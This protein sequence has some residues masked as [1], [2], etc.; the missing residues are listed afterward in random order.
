[1]FKTLVDWFT[2]SRNKL[3]P[4]EIFVRYC[5]FSDVSAH[6]TRFQEFSRERCFN[7]LLSTLENEQGVNVTFFLDTFHPMEREHFIRK[8]TQHPLVEF[9]AGSEAAS[10]L[11]MLEH[12]YNQDFSPDTIIYFLE[13]DY[14]HL[15]KWPQV[16]REAFTLPN[17]D[18]V[19]LYDHKDKYLFPQYADLKSKIFHTPSCHWRTTPSTTNTYSMLFKTLKKHID[20]HRCFSLGRKITADHEKF[21]KLGE[22]EAVLISSIPGYATHAEPEFASPGTDWEGVLLASSQATIV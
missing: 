17:I 5:H 13:D 1:M 19:T 20:L 8:Q 22:E 9:K 21:V 15:P 4:I 12:V 2:D 10:F 18:Y 7:N 14:L 16:L 3:L 6:K 11:F